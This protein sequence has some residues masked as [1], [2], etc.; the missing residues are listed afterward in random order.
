MKIEPG[1]Y[2]NIISKAIAER[3]A[4]LDR[5]GY[6]IKR[7]KIDSG[8]SYELLAGYLASVVGSILKDCFTLE[9]G[10]DTIGR[11][12]SV[13]NRILQFI[14]KEWHAEHVDTSLD[15][16]SPEDCQDL[17]RG[18]YSKMRLTDEQVEE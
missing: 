13:V 5:E 17:L 7:D 2:E 14:E 15:I 16:I 9:K 4:Q 18:I 3:L 6:Y 10:P 8:K 11:Q 1:V 12:V